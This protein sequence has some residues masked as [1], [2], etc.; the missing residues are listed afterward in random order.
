MFDITSIIL[1]QHPLNLYLCLLISKQIKSSIN[2][3]ADKIDNTCI[4]NMTNMETLNL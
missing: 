2:R 4:I 1:N 3:L